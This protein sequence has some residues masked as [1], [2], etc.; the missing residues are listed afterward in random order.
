[1]T[2]TPQPSSPNG[3]VTFDPQPPLPSG[4]VIDMPSDPDDGEFY[5]AQNGVRYR[6]D[7]VKWV[8]ASDSEYALWRYDGTDNTLTPAFAGVGV[9]TTKNDAQP[10]GSRSAAMQEEGYDVEVLPKLKPWL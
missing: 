2:Y 5:I 1:M 9:K 8:L 3:N 7:G 10:Y 4:F 6:W